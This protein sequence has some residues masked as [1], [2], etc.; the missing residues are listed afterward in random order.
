MNKYLILNKFIVYVLVLYFLT[1]ILIF[2]LIGYNNVL[3]FFHFSNIELLR[4]D[5]IRTIYYNHAQ[6]L[7]LNFLL[8]LLFKI[9]DGNIESIS[10]AFYFM[11][12]LLTIGIILISY[13]IM[14]LFNLNKK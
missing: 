8:G 11:H 3:D 1:R 2:N 5:L 9:F 12:I 4:T 7:L 10:V 14:T 13:E 6:P